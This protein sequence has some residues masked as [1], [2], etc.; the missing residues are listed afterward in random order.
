MRFESVTAHAFGPFTGKTLTFAAGMNVVHGPNEAG[1]STLHAALYA[2]LCG[3]R[4]GPG[5]GD[6]LTK[7]LTKDHRP[8]DSDRWEAAVTVALADG[9]C[10]ELRYN[11]S[12]KTCTATDAVLGT[13][14]PLSEIV[15]DGAPDGARWL[16][17]DRKAFLATA[18][19][20]QTDLLSVRHEADML[21]AYVQR[22]VATAGADAT[23]AE[24][25]ARIDAYKSE[26]VGTE[27]APTKPLRKAIDAVAAAERALEAS[28]QQHTAFAQLLEHEKVLKHARDHA[29]RQ[30][31][32]AEAKVATL[33]A[34]ALEQRAQRASELAARFPDGPPLS[35]AQDDT[36]A[37][38]VAVA[39][40]AWQSHRTVRPLDGDSSE[41]LQA[42]LDSLPE[43][44]TGDTTPHA[45]V[46]GA[47]HAYGAAVRTL[48]A[49]PAAP[50]PTPTSPHASDRQGLPR[51]PLIVGGAFVAAGVAAV[52]LVGPAAGAVLAAVGLGIIAWSFLR[53]QRASATAARAADQAAAVTQAAVAA[54]DALRE[55]FVR[56]RD[57][58][59][60][61]LTTALAARGV[62]LSSDPLA[63]AA[64]YERA[65]EARARQAAAASGRA[66]LES[67][68]RTRLEKEA[69]AAEAA[70]LR[71][72]ALSTLTDLAARCGIA[73]PEI[74][75]AGGDE[76]A[77]R[78]RAW[79]AQRSGNIAAL[80]DARDEW[81]L[82]QSLLEGT[83]L[84]DLQAEAAS[85]VETA[86][87]RAAGFEPQDLDELLLD[88]NVDGQ[89]ARLREDVRSASEAHAACRA[90]R[91]LSA[92]SLTS[93]ADGE[94]SLESARLE[95]ARVRRLDATLKQTR[96]VLVRAQDRVHRDI[97]PDL[98]ADVERW[99][100]TITGGRYRDVKIDPA[101]LD[102]TVMAPDGHRRQ[103]AQL[104]RGTAEQ[105]YL[106]L[107]TALAK[108]LTS[109]DEICPLILDDVTVHC[110]S[111]RK[112]RI[113]DALQALSQERQII[114]FSQED[115]VLTWAKE[116]LTG[117]D[118]RLLILDP[119]PA[120]VV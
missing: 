49:Q 13:P 19:V 65:C 30:L 96:D 83:T 59:L 91:E 64:A 47:R 7:V 118:E 28:R 23:A 72:K 80:S 69:G 6:D 88:A 1:K 25:I 93:V 99:L 41:V 21:R 26:H 100:P 36:L 55:T 84:E 62:A 87:E 75:E 9:R 24:A 98:A 50:P 22:A 17:L 105:V 53:A 56:Q 102:V 11:L 110:D 61:Q 32:L 42:Q 8:W 85:A 74:G 40:Q 114:L 78:L 5:K 37:Q 68:L 94:D 86:R 101:S 15:Y 109:K 63:D 116:T 112:V 20:R 14:V 46:T 81:A 39:L 95:L 103:A 2:G 44:P 58:S 38:N 18:C 119:A 16:G 48:E 97:A 76:T 45:D 92:T 60:A 108:R 120:P 115:P 43:L 54:R 106:L 35:A 73:A 113:L 57:A 51:L 71:T 111:S 4:K 90:Q 70:C 31:A 34:A 89:L 82:L 79:Q 29:D 10:I 12:N 117:Q 107:R 77:D 33:T 52:V 67:L 27:A 3:V 66:G 104:S